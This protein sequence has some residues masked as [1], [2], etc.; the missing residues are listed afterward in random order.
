MVG[1]R[2][3]CGGCRR[4]V[5]VR[6]EAVSLTFLVHAREESVSAASVPT[7]GEIT[8]AMRYAERGIYTVVPSCDGFA[9]CIA[10]VLPRALGGGMSQP[11]H[12]IAHS[13]TA[14][15]GGWV[16]PSPRITRSMPTGVSVTHAA[17]VWHITDAQQAASALQN[18][19]AQRAFMERLRA[20]VHTSL[21]TGATHNTL[22]D[23]WQVTVQPYVASVNG[24]LSWWASGAAASEANY[25]NTWPNPITSSASG[26]VPGPAADNPV[27]PNPPAPWSLFTLGMVGAGVLLTGYVVVQVTPALVE[28]FRSKRSEPKTA[29][30]SNPRRRR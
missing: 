9:Q 6:G 24:P 20:D 21:A 3:S 28:A 4:S 5:G 12:G 17:W 23:H 29:P 13:R 7:V 8:T 26:V 10:G 27:G 15:N 22:G 11:T 30:Q 16:G 25:I 19:T 18:D 2:R 14:V 1:I